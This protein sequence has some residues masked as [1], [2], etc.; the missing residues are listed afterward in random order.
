MG[1]AGIL[2][3]CSYARYVS[4]VDPVSPSRRRESRRE[5]S[6]EKRSPKARRPAKRPRNLHREVIVQAEAMFKEWPL[7]A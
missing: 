5:S 2:A 3:A 6:R 1:H 4:R 7:A